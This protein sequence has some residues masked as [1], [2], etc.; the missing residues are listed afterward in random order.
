MKAP[1]SQSELLQKMTFKQLFKPTMRTSSLLLYSTKNFQLWVS[2]Y[3]K[4][5]GNCIE[6]TKFHIDNW[7]HLKFSEATQL[8]NRPVHHNNQKM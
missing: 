8:I 4:L 7:Y 6:S 3:G 2:V 1:I 5:L